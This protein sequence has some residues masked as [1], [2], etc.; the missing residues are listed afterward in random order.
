VVAKERVPFVKYQNLCTGYSIKQIMI[1][2][3]QLPTYLPNDQLLSACEY[4]S[5]PQVQQAVVE[6]ADVNCLASTGWT[7]VMLAI[8][9]N[10][11]NVVKWLLS[12]ESVDVNYGQ[13]Y[14]TT[15]HTACWISD[16]QEI[17][18]QVATKSDNVNALNS[19][20]CTP[21]QLAIS[22]G[23]KNGVLGLLSVPEVNW[24]VKNSHGESLL[25]MARTKG[26]EEIAD[27]L[28]CHLTIFDDIKNEAHIVSM[29]DQMRTDNTS[30]IIK[31]KRRKKITLTTKF[32]SELSHS[33]AIKNLYRRASENGQEFCKSGL[34]VVGRHCSLATA[35]IQTSSMR[36][37]YE[38]DII[39]CI[40]ISFSLK[41]GHNFKNISNT[42]DYF[43]NV[44]NKSFDSEEKPTRIVSL[45]KVKSLLKKKGKSLRKKENH[46]PEEM[47]PST[48][49]TLPPMKSSLD[50]LFKHCVLEQH[51]FITKLEEAGSYWLS[52]L[53]YTLDVD[54]QLDLFGKKAGQH[55]AMNSFCMV[56]TLVKYIA[57]GGENMVRQREYLI[58]MLIAVDK[59]ENYNRD[60]GATR[61][62]ETLKL[63]M[64]SSKQL[65][66]WIESVDSKYPL[67]KKIKWKRNLISFFKNIVLGFGLFMGDVGT[68]GLFTY[69]MIR[70]YE[71]SQDNLDISPCNEELEDDY[72]KIENACNR[73][74]L[75]KDGVASCLT[76]LNAASV[77]VRDC[78]HKEV[79]K[80]NQ[81]NDWYIMFLISLSHMIIPLV[82]CAI[83]GFVLAKKEETMVENTRPF[84]FMGKDKNV[85]F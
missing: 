76:S 29:G 80:F 1:K 20:G 81:P 15:L 6:G 85:S 19:S 44:A 63:N 49:I 43:E 14:G 53:F 40:D 68:D 71:E 5:I 36:Q 41:A 72:D 54:D 9:H 22:K 51:K 10:H 12:L 11:N 83:C 67:P 4:G 70:L 45:K 61:I 7:P 59:I 33:F 13:T 48:M 18:R 27:L 56:D 39:G 25:D 28:M 46:Q 77:A 35:I 57:K 60:D 73:F 42:I 78:F 79:S 16:D 24:E 47:V 84:A 23:N 82:L 38:D 64:E 8:L 26:H 30:F 34:E 2:T 62:I 66:N 32:R 31:I 17:V 74:Q 37:E 50:Y 52:T 69:S 58:T 65:S 3:K 55:D 75:Q 21:A